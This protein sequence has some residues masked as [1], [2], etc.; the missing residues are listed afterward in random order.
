MVEG[1]G[2]IEGD[3][4]LIEISPV[5]TGDPPLSPRV[6]LFRQNQWVSEV[7]REGVVEVAEKVVATGKEAVLDLIQGLENTKAISFGGNI[8][9]RVSESGGNGKEVMNGEEISKVGV[10]K[11]W[12]NAAHR[13]RSCS[14]I[15]NQMSSEG[16]MNS[17]SSSNGFAV[18]QDLCE[19]GEI[20]EEG[21]CE[22][23][24]ET[25]KVSGEVEED[26]E[27]ARMGTS[28][29]NS[30]ARWLHLGFTVVGSK[31]GSRY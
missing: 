18:L 22:V 29:W 24:E 2:D 26:L 12:K 20:M 8:T 9:G 30:V 6:S 11:Q 4:T 1:D 10:E 14:P 5:A 17:A 23:V 31:G 27:E 3:K 15:G 21:E 28:R 19:E 25:K 16:R 13:G 7:H